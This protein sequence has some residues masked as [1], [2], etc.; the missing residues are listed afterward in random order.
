MARPKPVFTPNPRIWTQYQTA[1]R[2]NKSEQWFMNNRRAL[3]QIGFPPKDALLGGWD[4]NL[5]EAWLDNR[6][7][8]RDASNI[9]KQ[10]LEAVCGKNKPA[11]RPEERC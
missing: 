2:L 8:A 5:I 7:G 3:E 1:C 11:I 10:M 9:E 6:S 4:A